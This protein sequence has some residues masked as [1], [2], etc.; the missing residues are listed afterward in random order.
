MTASGTS[1]QDLGLE[2]TN[3]LKATRCP[4]G[5]CFASAAIKAHDD[6]IAW[7]RGLA[8]EEN[9]QARILFQQMQQIRAER[10]RRLPFLPRMIWRAADWLD[11]LAR[12][13]RRLAAKCRSQSR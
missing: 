5:D 4:E 11:H 3:S 12:S 7:C 10:L 8:P 6:L 2:A 1:I 13:L 9:P